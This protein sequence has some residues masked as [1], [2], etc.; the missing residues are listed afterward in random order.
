MPQ[1]FISTHHGL[2]TR[3]NDFCWTI[4]GEVVIVPL[5]ECD[6]ER[7]DDRCGCRRSFTGIDTGRGTTTFEVVNAVTGAEKLAARLFVN[8][9]TKGWPVTMEQMQ[10]FA[11]E[12][13]DF[14]QQFDVGRIYERRG[15]RIQ[16][17]GVAALQPGKS[18]LVPSNLRAR[19]T[20]RMAPN[21]TA[22]RAEQLT[23]A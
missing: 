19:V 5:I 17:R 18:I 20:E 23:T 2:G 12:Y 13:L 1:L 8:L 21:R 4:P 14:V 9:F 10:G 22:S 7:V 6:L 3:T 15:N 11:E 16:E